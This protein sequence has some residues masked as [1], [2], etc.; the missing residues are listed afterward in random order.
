MIIFHVMILHHALGHD[1]ALCN[2]N[3]HCAADT[4]RNEANQGGIGH[5]SGIKGRFAG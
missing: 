3:T 2:G 4:L 1:N 5:E